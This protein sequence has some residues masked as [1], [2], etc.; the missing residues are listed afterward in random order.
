MPASSRRIRSRP[1]TAAAW[2]IDLS[3]TGVKALRLEFHSKEDR[4]EATAWD[5]I[6]GRLY[7]K[8]SAQAQQIWLTNP[9]RYIKEG[10]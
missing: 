2:G 8:E 5:V 6:D 10:E 1:T 9:Y 4:V 3:S 7:V